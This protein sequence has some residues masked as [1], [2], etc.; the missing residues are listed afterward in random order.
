MPTFIKLKE[1]NGFDLSKMK[2]AVSPWDGRGTVR[3]VT[4]CLLR[5]IGV[6]YA[7]YHRSYT[8][9]EFKGK[10][11]NVRFAVL[12][13]PFDGAIVAGIDIE[14]LARSSSTLTAPFTIFLF[15]DIF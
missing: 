8:D 11:G 1:S 7:W 10:D 9:L 3:F 13:S 6:T 15:R 4:L 12:N 14:L 2:S 5:S